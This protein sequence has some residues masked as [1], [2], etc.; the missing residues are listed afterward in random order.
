MGE[1]ELNKEQSEIKTEVKK[2]YYDFPWLDLEDRS[3]TSKTL[4]D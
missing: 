4:K 3:N 1:P 2:L